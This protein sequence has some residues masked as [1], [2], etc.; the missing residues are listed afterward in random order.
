[1]R[2]FFGVQTISQKIDDESVKKCEYSI[3]ES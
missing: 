3:K 1:M 2:T